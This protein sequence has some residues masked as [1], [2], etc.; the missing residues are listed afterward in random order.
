MSTGAGERGG[1]EDLEEHQPRR[2]ALRA[3]RALR[4]AAGADAPATDLA[5][6][7][8]AAAAEALGAEG[9]TIS[10]LFAPGMSVPVGVS[11]QVAARAEQLQFTAGEGPCWEAY[12]TG[13]AVVADLSDV[14]TSRRRWPAYARALQ[15]ETGYALVVAVPVRLAS[16]LLVALNTY[17]ASPAGPPWWLDASRVGAALGEVLD[18]ASPPPSAGGAVWLDSS[19]TARRSTVWTAEAVL[20]DNAPFLDHDSALDALRTYSLIEGTTVDDA[21]AAL[22]AGRLTTREVLGR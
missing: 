13:V 17:E 19:T 21:A 18:E 8:A 14:P 3:A 15:H 2:T 11:D 4:A 7:L 6:R 22:L 9:A 16:G 1:G 12:R 5:D 20:I 10:A